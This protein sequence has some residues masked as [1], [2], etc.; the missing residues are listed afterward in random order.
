MSCHYVS[1]HQS[2]SF[3]LYELLL[4]P[5]SSLTFVFSFLY[6]FGTPTVA[7]WLVLFL[8]V[9]LHVY[10]IER[11]LVPVHFLLEEQISSGSLFVRFLCQ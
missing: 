2:F 9:F 5:V 8:F 6:Y 1:Y 7:L 4:F 3:L 10:I 11:D